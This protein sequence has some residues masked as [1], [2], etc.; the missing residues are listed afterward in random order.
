MPTLSATSTAC[1]SRIVPIPI[2]IK[3]LGL[4]QKELLCL[5]EVLGSLAKPPHTRYI[6][7]RAY[8]DIFLRLV[9][10]YMPLLNLLL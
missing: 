6:Y 2:H 5:R 3:G 9:Q 8:R 1:L 4:T 10:Q 7:L